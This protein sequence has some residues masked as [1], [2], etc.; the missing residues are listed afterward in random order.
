MSSQSSDTDRSPAAAV[1]LVGGSGVMARLGVE[2]GVAV[3][4]SVGV[5]VELHCGADLLLDSLRAACGGAA[6]LLVRGPMEMVFIKPVDRGWK[7]EAMIA[8]MPMS[9]QPK[10]AAA[11]GEGNA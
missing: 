4:E 11:E 1:R 6:E 5:A 7:D 3:G 8:M 10:R 2:V 9:A